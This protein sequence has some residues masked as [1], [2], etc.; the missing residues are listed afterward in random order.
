M[1]PRTRAL[2]WLGFLAFLAGCSADPPRLAE[3]G[4]AAGMNVLVVTVDTLRADRLGCYGHAGARTPTIDGLAGNWLRFERATTVSPI[5]LP[6][7]AS[8]FTG[9]EVPNH[10]VRHNGTFRLS[11]D[12]TTLAERF[13][14]AGYD[15]A[16]FVSAYVLER[17]FGLSQGF[18]KYDDRFDAHDPG[19]GS[20][21]ERPADR[22]TDRVIERLDS[23]GRAS[24]RPFFAWIHY[25]DPHGPYEPP[26]PFDESFAEAPYDGEVAFVDRELGRLLRALDTHEETLVVFTSDHGE[27]LGDHGEVTHADLIYDSTMRV[28]LI[29]SNPRLFPGGE[30]VHD[31]LAATIDVVPTVVALV[32]L[33]GATGASSPLDGVD[34]AAAPDDDRAVYLETLAPLLDSAGHRCTVCDGSTTSSSTRRSRSTTT[35]TPTLPSS[36]ISTLGRTAPAVCAWRSPRGWA[37]G[38]IHSRSQVSSRS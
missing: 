23:R 22:V 34:L 15:T 16:A 32:G 24:D 3:P 1:E 21:P 9:L 28:P 31:R 2:A 38:P 26:A 27:G 7:H 6:S 36:P 13:S 18:D 35:S 4:G 8:I 19:P 20:Y 30:V 12:H 17:R 11:P 25:F 14:A 10:G 37:A 29:I 33:P 5:T